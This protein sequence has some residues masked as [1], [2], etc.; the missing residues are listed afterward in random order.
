MLL[1]LIGKFFQA[2]LSL[3]GNIVS[4]FLSPVNQL[5]ET[6]LPDL[7]NSIN[8]V[9]NSLNGMFIGVSY[10]ISY[11]PSSVRLTLLFI[12]SVEIANFTIWRST[13]AVSVMWKIIKQIKFW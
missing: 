6:L 12:L 2:I 8:D 7:S 11:I 1:G 3:I 9:V 10:A 5:F 4:I 13:K